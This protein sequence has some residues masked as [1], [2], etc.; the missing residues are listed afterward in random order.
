L[1]ALL[2][3]EHSIS[4]GAAPRKHSLPG[5]VRACVFEYMEGEKRMVCSGYNLRFSLS[6]FVVG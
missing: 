6:F 1:P 4:V 3:D 2:R 5:N